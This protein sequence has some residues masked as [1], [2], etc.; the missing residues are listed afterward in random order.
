MGRANEWIVRRP[1]AVSAPVALITLLLS[2][3]VHPDGFGCGAGKLW[4]SPLIALISCLFAFLPMSKVRGGGT[5]TCD[6]RTTAEVGQLEHDWCISGPLLG[7]AARRIVEPGTGAVG[8]VV[9]AGEGI[10]GWAVAESP[11]GDRRHGLQRPH[12]LFVARAR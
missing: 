3:L 2:E 5:G 1:A 4:L 12:Q 10:A 8:A 11:A 9:T 7:C 6:Q